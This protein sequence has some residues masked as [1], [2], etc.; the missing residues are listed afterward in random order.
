MAFSKMKRT[1]GSKEVKGLGT[2]LAVQL[3]GLSTCTAWNMGS[4]FGW[5]TKILQ[6][7]WHSIKKERKEE[8]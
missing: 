5:G 4:I 6:D 7:T 2:S 1:H 3:L 8:S